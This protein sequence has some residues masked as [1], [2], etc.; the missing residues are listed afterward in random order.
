MRAINQTTETVAGV[1]VT[2][3][4]FEVMNSPDRTP[5][6]TQKDVYIVNDPAD[7]VPV[8]NAVA[9][10][11]AMVNYFSLPARTGANGTEF[12]KGKIWADPDNSMLSVATVTFSFDIEPCDSTCGTLPYADSGRD[13]TLQGLGVTYNAN[14]LVGFTLTT[15]FF[16]L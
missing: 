4:T 5:E 15:G 3:V 10:T 11:G 12:A 2:K 13:V 6:Q 7:Y 8:Y 16:E 14:G 9:P 1:S